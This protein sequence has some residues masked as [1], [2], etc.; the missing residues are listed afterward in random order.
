MNYPFKNLAIK[1][2]GIRGIAYLGAMEVMQEKGILQQLKAVS[3]ASAG[4]ITALVTALCYKD[5]DSLKKTANT[6][7]F[8][9]VAHKEKLLHNLSDIFM[10]KG[11]HS[12]KYIY[13]WFLQV[14]KDKLGNADITFKAFAEH[15]DTLELHIAITNVSGQQ[16]VICNHFTTPNEK[17][18]DVVR[19]SMNIPIYFEAN[20][21]DDAV[22]K[23]FYG[24]GGVM[25]NYPIG[26]WDTEDGPSDETIGLFLYSK[27]KPTN[28]PHHYKL[29]QYAADTME[30]LLLAQD[31]AM[32][33]TPGDLKRSIQIYDTG[34]SPVAF[35]VQLGDKVYNALYESGKKAA[36]D[37][38]RNYDS[39]AYDQLEASK[40]STSFESVMGTALSK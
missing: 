27:E 10:R 39:G 18:A 26:L 21:Y 16:S 12:S 31:W 4:A 7:E 1:G 25:C 30:S 8:S 14:L 20:K 11:F 23:G 38:F 22:L 17:V 19:T 36:T 40:F 37:Y 13:T 24:D 34:V 35:D 28:M 33:R 32:S 5:F 2:G 6:M 9:K 3:G 29:K 15:P